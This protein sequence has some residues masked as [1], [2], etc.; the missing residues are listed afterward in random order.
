M[1]AVWQWISTGRTGQDDR[2]QRGTVVW[3]K[4]VKPN[5]SSGS[6]SHVCSLFALLCF[7]ARSF[8]DLWCLIRLVHLAFS[9]SQIDNLSASFGTINYPGRRTLAGTACGLVKSES[10]WSVWSCYWANHMCPVAMYGYL[11]SIYSFHFRLSTSLLSLLCVCVCAH[12]CTLV[13]RGVVGRGAG[14]DEK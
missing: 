10:A 13:Y 14:E 8:A 4:A 7:A 6:K 2:W 11:L 3:K 9:V 5:G 12:V 1:A